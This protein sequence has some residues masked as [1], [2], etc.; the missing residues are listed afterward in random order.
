MALPLPA[1]RSLTGDLYDVQNA[2]T[3]DALEKRK[4][5]ITNQYLPRNLS[6]KAQAEEAYA[7]LLGPQFTAKLIGNENILSQIKD[8]KAREIIQG[9]VNAGIGTSNNSLQYQPGMPQTNSSSGNALLDMAIGG[10]PKGMSTLMG[11][12][13]GQSPTRS[14]FQNNGVSQPQPLSNISA[15]DMR[16]GMVGYNEPL[17][18]NRDQEEPSIAENAGKFKGIIEEGQESGKIRAKDIE[19]LNDTVFNGQTNQST[20]DE[21]STIL[22]SPEFEQIRKFPLAGRYELSYYSKFG[23]PEQQQLIGKYYTLA[24]NIIKNSARDFP[25]QF[26]KGE[27]Q[28]LEGMKPNPSDTVNIARGKTE[29]LSVMNKLLTER[30][31]LTSQLMSKMHVNKLEAQEL[32]DKQINGEDIRKQIH[33]K[34]NPT[35]TVRNKKTGEVK[36][37]S[38]SEARKLGVPNV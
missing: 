25:G 14:Q 27:Q 35:I 12:N 37:L 20:L 36:T 18:P 23:T 6:A 2:L 26:R 31:R 22:S 33:N 15:D 29:A 13:Q 28:L 4:Q 11:G 24:G 16:E 7:R 9:I 17:V 21:L 1:P 8:P 19:N 10:I 30:A 3:K 5:E 34:L 32:S 38:V